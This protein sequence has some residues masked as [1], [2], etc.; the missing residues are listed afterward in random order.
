MWARTRSCRRRSTSSCPRRAPSVR[1]ADRDGP[2]ARTRQRARAEP[3]NVF[4]TGASSGIGEALASHYAALGA[5]VGLF[6]R[7]EAALARVAAAMAPTHVAPYVG[8]V[9]D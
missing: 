8:D 6:A 2:R 3:M 5:H 1:R 9:R 4:I 7:R